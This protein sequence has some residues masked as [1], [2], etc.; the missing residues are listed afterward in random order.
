MR[1]ALV[2][3]LPTALHL[4]L[5]EPPQEMV[6]IFRLTQLG[7]SGSGANDTTTTG[8]PCQ[9]PFAVGATTLTLANRSLER[10]PRC[11]PR[12][13]RSLDG[14][15]NLLSTLSASELGPLPELQVLNLHHNR[16][17]AL[18][19]DPG[20]P[21]GLH[22]LDLS[23]NRLAALPPCT[24]PVLGSLRALELAGNPLR[25]LPPGALACFPSLRLLNLSGTA[26]GQGGIADAA[27][28]PLASLEVLD[29]SGTL[30][31]QV[32][33]RWIQDLPKLTSLHL[34]KMP[35]LRSL[36][37]DIFKTASDLQQLDCQ[38]SL[39]LTSVQTLIFQDTPRL[40]LL[41]L[42]NCNLSSFPPWTLHSSQVLS[43]NLFGNPLTCSCELSWLLKDVN[44]TILS[45]AADTVCTPA[46][47]SRGALSAPLPL[48]Q[49]PGVC[50]GDQ[51]TVLLDPRPPISAG[52]THATSTP[53]P[54]APQLST[55]TSSP[56]GGGRR[57]VT[58]AP[59]HAVST[60]AWATAVS[61]AG[62]RN[63]SAASRAWT[64]HERTAPP[65]PDPPVSAASIPPAS[66]Q[67][68][69]PAASRNPLST[70]RHSRTTQATPQPP[71]PSPSEEGGIPVLVLDD[72]SEE[73]EE[74]EGK[75]GKEKVVSAPPQGVACD[76]HP[77]KH[78]QTPCA[79]LQRR[80][81]CQCPG[82]SQE[83]AV[84]EPP[85][86]Q[87]LSEVTDT[88]A[89]VRWCAPNS[90]VRSYQIR[91]SPEGGPGNQSAAVGDIYATARQ[92]PLY[93]LSPGTTYRVCVLAA[94]GA[95]LSPTQAPG[96]REPCASF[97]T[98][99]SSVLILAGLSA[100]GGLL[101][102]STLV[103]SAC[104]CRRGRRQSYPAHLVAYKNPAF[105][106]PLKLQTFS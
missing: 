67:R 11:L 76:Y 59:S 33:P 89:L 34:R 68:G 64:E 14:S 92:H 38:D 65:D 57:T 75:K 90:V 19:W 79:E 82:F 24:R 96:R 1:L 104:L 86:L 101:L 49:L 37:G 99:P 98:K 3:L 52:P 80:S 40:Q 77:C 28:A 70:P 81:R 30:L 39:A 87:G 21:A 35:M 36:E 66:K 9:G 15:H 56:A 95:G 78:L 50:H 31:K 84:P 58:K 100:A 69:L 73:E 2:L 44:R 8:S 45:R 41:L 88:S 46:A 23:H 105:D 51:S 22:T 42:Q 18:R 5:A 85:K 32:Q 61:I 55:A 97:T 6:P 10:L 102:V 20:W 74:E 27:F 60:P 63:S 16:I 54:F 93:G 106:D 83:D 91:Y 43:I 26:L 12:A 94:N 62:P 53:G 71:H 103:L 47:G 17:G 7:P 29:L 48:S 72:S 25:A 13:L 4:S